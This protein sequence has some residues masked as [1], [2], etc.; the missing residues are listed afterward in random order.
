MY[1]QL[2]RPIL[3]RLGKGDA[4]GAHERTMALLALV[5]RSRLLLGALERAFAF[6]SAALARTYFGLRFPNPVGLAAGMD[7]DGLALPAWAALGFGFVEVGTVTWHAQPGNPRPRLFRLPHDGALINRMGFN[8]HGAAALATRLAAA[9]PLGVPLGISIGKSKLAPLEQATDDYVASLRALHAH[10]DYIAVNV[11]SPNTPGLRTL[12]DRAQLDGLLAALA[13]E[14]IAIAQQRNSAPRP[15]LVKLAPDLSDSAMLELLEVCVHN[16]VSGIIAT[17]TTV[18]RAGLTLAEPHLSAEAGGLSGRPL[19]ARALDVVRLVARASGGRL[20]IIGVGGIASPDDALRMLEA[21]ADL[22]QLY[23]GL[24]YEG[25]GLPGRITR[26]LAQRRPR[27][28]E[29][30]HPSPL[31]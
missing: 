16:G 2:I 21:G 19:A 12:Q 20:P 3:F 8:N 14:N 1:K 17:N 23:T 11:S 27:K 26:A 6:S 10:A 13:R 31:L 5:S 15:I 30:T 25:P 18:S 29:A 9:P 24:I 28:A 7:K 22:V 4:E